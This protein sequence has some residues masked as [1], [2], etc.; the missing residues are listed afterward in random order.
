MKLIFILFLTLSVSL[1]F[2]QDSP[3]KNRWTIKA[4]HSKY[5]IGQRAA[6]RLNRDPS[7]SDL[8]RNLEL[9][10]GISKNIELGLY[11]G[12]FLGKWRNGKLLGIQT[13]Y[14]ILPLFINA[15]D[16]RFDIYLCGKLGAFIPP[17][18]YSDKS[19]LLDL[20]L[21]IGGAF[22]PFKHLGVFY[23]YYFGDLPF[24]YNQS[25]KLGIVY[26]FRKR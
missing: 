2:S 13:N 19:L 1:A 25:F 26:K 20:G 3:I 18:T 12:L 24:F 11:G 14:H 15:K 10:Y 21:G 7:T 5:K 23:E 9:N 4:Y 16:F 22:Y 17:E 6:S 8:Y